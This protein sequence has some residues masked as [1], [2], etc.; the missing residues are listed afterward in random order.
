MGEGVSDVTHHGGLGDRHSLRVESW[1]MGWQG[2]S[3]VSHRMN[4]DVSDGLGS[5]LLVSGGCS[6]SC[7]D[8]LRGGGGGARRRG[9]MSQLF[10]IGWQAMIDSLND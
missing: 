6:R 3:Q 9:N 2:T 10:V 4:G 1:K 8:W 5:N 7:C